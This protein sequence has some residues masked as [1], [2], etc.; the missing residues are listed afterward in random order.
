LDQFLKTIEDRQNLAVSGAS[1][2][3]D[4]KEKCIRKYFGKHTADILKDKA[5]MISHYHANSFIED[6]TR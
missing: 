4:Q 5:S 6:V 1:I 2:A 3:P